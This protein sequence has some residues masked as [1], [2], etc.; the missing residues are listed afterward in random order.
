MRPVAYTQ[1][2]P[3]ASTV[4]EAVEPLLGRRVSACFWVGE[5]Q[6]VG[7]D[8]VLVAMQVR[9]REGAREV[10]RLDFGEE[11]GEEVGWLD[12][13]VAE[14]LRISGGAARASVELDLGGGDVLVLDPV[15]A[16]VSGIEGAAAAAGARDE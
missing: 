16:G 9:F 4:L 5:R 6:A 1:K 2:V 12:V 14:L 8:G 10:V 15:Y 13:P 7:M 3:S 11:D